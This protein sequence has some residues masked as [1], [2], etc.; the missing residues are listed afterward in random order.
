MYSPENVRTL[1]VR[2]ATLKLTETDDD[3]G[4]ITRS[5]QQ[6]GIACVVFFPGCRPCTTCGIPVGNQNLGGYS[7]RCALSG[8]LFCLGCSDRRTPP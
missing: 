2:S 1:P 6:T 4:N 8:S 7:G 3:N 5:R